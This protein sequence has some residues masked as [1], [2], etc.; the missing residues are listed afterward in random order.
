[1]NHKKESGTS[2]ILSMV[3]CSF[4][5]II[6]ALCSYITIPIIIP[7]TL[8]TLGVFTALE[9]LGGKKG[10][11]S[12]L[13]YILLGA[14]GIPVFSG[15]RGGIGIL[16]S[17]TG[18]YILGFLFLAIT[19]Y[20]ITHIAGNR[21]FIRILAMIS[22][23]LVCYTFGTLWF[24]LAYSDI[25]S[26]HEIFPILQ[27]CVLPFFIPDIIKIGVAVTL[28]KILYPSLPDTLKNDSFRKKN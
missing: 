5:A 15:F 2:R 10:I 4:F 16:L 22:G 25:Q 21:L 11:F 23:L 20:L 26:M 13:L 28:R 8:Q 6:I 18:G 27:V 1:M 3:Y 17:N 12:V 14:V 19:Y 9:L 24:V 7:F